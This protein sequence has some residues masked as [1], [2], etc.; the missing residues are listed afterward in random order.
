MSFPDLSH[1]V[2]ALGT[3]CLAGAVVGCAFTLAEIYF[4]LRFPRRGACGVATPPSMTVLKPLHGS[5]PGLRDRLRRLCTQRYD[6]AVQIVCGAHG[7]MSVAAEISAL[8]EEFP[9]CDIALV[10][11]PRSH[12][13]NG[14]ISNLVNM[15][16]HAR[17]DT[18]VVSD[19]DIEVD[20]DYLSALAALLEQPRVGAVTCLY[21]GTGETWWQRL[22]A[23]AITA[24]YLP[25]IILSIGLG[26]SQHC[27]GATIALRRPVLEE[28]GGFAA[29]ADE[30][31][32]DHAIGA[33]VRTAGYDIV[34]APFLVGH[35]CLE[36]GL[37][38][39]CQRQLRAARTV[40]SVAP[41]G[42]AG[43]LLGH[44]LPLAALGALSGSSVAALI[45]GL[46]LTTRVLLYLC[47]ARRFDLA[48][49]DCWLL[50]LHDMLA[51]A[52][53][54]ASFFGRTVHWRGADYR[55]TA[56]G[57]LIERAAE[58]YLSAESS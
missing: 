56:K 44:T 47:M 43:T 40:R 46:T 32:D 45:A 42:H 33:A 24:R 7:D 51:F 31:A 55:V 25:Q 14:K 22:S 26:V 29:F 17:Y 3:I 54:L 34:T 12:G 11:D 16:P 13:S 35:R 38:D 5:E 57:A 6:G 53:F 49:R 27:C 10:A 20:E 18:I 15:L 39:Y 21:Y 41:V 19:S 23:L 58:G 50:P 37:R 28:I 52:V 2:Q 36:T 1:C 9:D 48:R 4:V 8:K 30:L